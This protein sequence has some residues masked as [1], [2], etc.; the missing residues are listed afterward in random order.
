MITVAAGGIRTVN[1]NVVKVWLLPFVKR[2]W[3][4]AGSVM[5]T[6]TAYQITVPGH[7]CVGCWRLLLLTMGA[8]FLTMGAKSGGGS[9]S[10]E[11]FRTELFE[12][13]KCPIYMGIKKLFHL[14]RKVVNIIQTR[15][16]TNII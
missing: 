16:S 4:L 7:L 3:D 5:R 15:N 14:P 2:N 12:V 6:L 1:L 8:M 13:I 10:S 9:F 11:D